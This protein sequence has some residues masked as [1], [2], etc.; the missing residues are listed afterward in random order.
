MKKILINLAIV[1]FGSLMTIL[2]FSFIKWDIRWVTYDSLLAIL[3]KIFALVIGV[4][5]AAALESQ[6]KEY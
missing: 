5:C 6:K 2:V 3:G 1:I 4:A